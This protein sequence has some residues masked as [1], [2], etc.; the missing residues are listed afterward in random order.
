M[1]QELW[2]FVWFVTFVWFLLLTALKHWCKN[3]LFSSEKKPCQ[4]LLFT[5]YVISEWHRKGTFNC[6]I[7]NNHELKGGTVTLQTFQRF[8]NVVA[9]LTGR[10][11]VEQRQIN[12]E[13]TLLRQGWNLQGL[14]TSNQPCIFQRW[15]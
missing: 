3:D 11:T 5:G 9:R 10:Q 13:T 6:E 14:T 1:T 8:F 7:V 2:N 4:E 15:Y 12:V